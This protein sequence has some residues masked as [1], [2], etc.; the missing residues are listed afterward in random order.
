MRT[1]RRSAVEQIFVRLPH[2]VAF[3]DHAFVVQMLQVVVRFLSDGFLVG[4]LLFSSAG[5]LAWQRAWA[6]LAV[7]VVV[8][9]LG[10]LMVY[11][12]N[13]ALVRGRAKYALHGEQATIDRLLMLAVLATGFLGL[14]MIAGFD[15]FRWHV[16][17]QPAPLLGFLGLGLFILG[18]CLK[19]LAMWANAFATA[20]VR[21]QSERAHTVADSGAYAFVRHP[22]YAADPLIFIGLGLWLQSFLTVLCAVVPVSLMMIR[23]HFE[24]RF[25]RRELPGYAEYTVRVPYRLIPGIW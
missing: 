12:V 22:F 4:A 2:G 6:L 10:A 3:F 16:L 14:P 17:P 19:N 24:E 23:I 13:F 15:V 7:L 9:T 1:C 5:T 11:R 20:E 8:R 21:L 25:L 18:W